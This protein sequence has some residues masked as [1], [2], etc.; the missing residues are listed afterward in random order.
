MTRGLQLW[1]E[2]VNAA[3][4]LG[5]A[6]VELRLEDDESDAEVAR[7]QFERLGPESD[8]LIAP[9][10]SWLT[11]AI[12]PVVERVGRP[13]LAPTAGERALWR[14]PRAW[15][16]QMLNPSDTMFNPLLDAAAAA[17]LQSVAL[18]FRGDPFS[19]AVVGG[20]IRHAF[21]SGFDVTASLSYDDEAG[22]RRQA[23]ELA[24]LG[25]VDLLI[26]AGFQPGIGFL[27]DALLLLDALTSAGIKARLWSFGIAAA[28]PTFADAAGK[29]VDG[30]LGS[31][32]WQPYLATAGNREFV[33]AYQQRWGEPPDIHAAHAYAV[34]QLFARAWTT[35]SVGGAH[36]DHAAV[37]D[38]LFGLD[39]ETVFGRFR[40]DDRGLQVGKANVVV[41]WQDGRPTVVWPKRYASGT[42]RLA[43]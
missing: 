11:E 23:Q 41:Q 27:D 20:A 24:L 6:G 16:A 2:Q 32:G 17:G 19:R 25:P 37:R 38:A 43:G 15:V 42:L 34:G 29:S 4:L 33:E 21:A 3:G 39:T 28:L 10:G 22:A 40:V 36:P 7:A 8:L 18:L 1:R 13:C 5:P 35:A 30:M 9:Y 12:L 31:T 14:E 26:A